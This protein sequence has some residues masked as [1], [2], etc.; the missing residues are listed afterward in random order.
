MRQHGFNTYITSAGPD[1]VPRTLGDG[2]ITRHV[3]QLFGH[4][5]VSDETIAAWKDVGADPQEGV[6]FVG[7]DD[8]AIIQTEV[9]D[10]RVGDGDQ[11]IGI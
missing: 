2:S 3:M 8:R 6:I 5:A 1:D 4:F 11:I 10:H 7:D 9:S